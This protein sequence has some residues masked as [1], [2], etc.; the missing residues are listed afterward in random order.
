MGELEHTGILETQ[1]IVE[2]ESSA[3]PPTLKLPVQVAAWG[4]T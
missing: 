2:W 4:P 1:E 3:H